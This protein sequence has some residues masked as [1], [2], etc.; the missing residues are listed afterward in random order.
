MTLL[1]LAIAPGIVICFY[2]FYKDMYNPEPIMKLII[3][4][5]LGAF[6]VVPAAVVERLATP[7]FDNTVL[8]TA[9]FAYGVVALTE[10]LG[11]FIVLRYYAYPKQSFDEP[12]DGIVYGI[13]AGMGFATVENIL[14]VS[15]NGY[16]TAIVRMFLSVPAHA[17]FA[18][19]MGYFAGKAKFNKAQSGALLLTGLLVAVFF[20]G[21]FDFLLFLQKSPYV[22]PYV[23]DGFLF[24]GAIASFF[25]AVRLSK[26]LIN[27][28]QLLSQR[29][30]S[31]ISGRV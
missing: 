8:S 13:M 31:N 4:F 14:Y 28:H 12:L 11:K 15:Q 29:T 30:F 2:I 24:I 10:E 5:I 1:A 21:T 22:T 6:V 7:Y 16:G 17:T 23:S 26:R 27:E 3:S 9:F 20:H 19:L 25:V 18:V